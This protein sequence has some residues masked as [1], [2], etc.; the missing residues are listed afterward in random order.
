MRPILAL[1]IGLLLSA[2]ASIAEAQSGTTYRCIGK[3]GRVVIAD[4]PCSGPT[5]IGA[6]PQSAG[7]QAPGA[8][9]SG[10]GPVEETPQQRAGSSYRPPSY[11]SAARSGP[12]NEALYRNLSPRCQSIHDGMRNADINGLKPETRMDLQ[13]A[14]NNECREDVSAAQRKVWDERRR[15]QQARAEQEAQKQLDAQADARQARICSEMKSVYLSRKQKNLNEA[16]RAEFQKFEQNYFERCGKP[17][18]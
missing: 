14:W 4:S 8:R 7:S 16:E 5:N 18:S 2:C 6:A 17:A 15:D 9:I 11:G 10:Y 3:D 1:T 13:R 12:A